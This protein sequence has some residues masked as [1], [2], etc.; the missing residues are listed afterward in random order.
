MNRTKPRPLRNLTSTLCNKTQK[1]QTLQY[2]VKSSQVSNPHKSK[3]SQSSSSK[4]FKCACGVLWCCSSG[5]SASGWADIRII[6]LSC[7]V[8]F[9]F[10]FFFLIFCGHPFEENL[11][12]KKSNRRFIPPFTPPR[13]IFSWGC[14]LDQRCFLLS[15]HFIESSFVAVFFLGWLHF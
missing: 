5:F 14:C 8:W 11:C 9:F 4:N 10:D 15:P 12:F 1:Q 3:S 2:Q 13:F 7:S 6:P